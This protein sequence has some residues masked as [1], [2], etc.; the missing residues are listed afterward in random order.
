MKLRLTPL[1]FATAFL[2]VLA[3]ITWFYKPVSVTGTELKQWTGTIAI[4][5]LTFAVF[6]FFLDMLFRNYFLQIKMLWMV[7]IAFIIL[8][9]VIYLIVR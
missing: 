7:E 4:I 9:A 1:N 8:T 3:F 6:S 5:F 2:I